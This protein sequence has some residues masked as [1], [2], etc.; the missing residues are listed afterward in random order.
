MTRRLAPQPW[1]AASATRRLFAAL[2]A[3]GAAVRFV[4]GCVR[5]TLLGRPVKDIDLATDATPEQVMAL[6]KSAGIKAVPT[7]IAHGTVTAIVDG[8]PYEI[9]TLRVDVETDGRHATVAYGT[10]WQADAARR[11][12]TINAMSLAPDGILFDPFGGADDLAAGRIR[13]VGTARDRIIEDVLRLLRWFRFHAFYGRP[14]PDAEALDACRTLAPRLAGLSRE[15]VRQETLRLLEAPDPVP[16]L[17]LMRETGVLAQL[18]DGATT[19]DR[20]AGLRRIEERVGLTPDP[21]LRLAALLPEV[22]G[23]AESTSKRLRLSKA[24]RDRLAALLAGGPVPTPVLDGQARRA[25]AYRLG[26]AIARDRILLAWASEPEG[27]GW[28]ALYDDIGAWPV[29]RL[30]VAGRDARKLGVP[31]GPRVGELLRAVEAWW[32][33]EDFHPDRAACLARLRSLAGH[34]TAQD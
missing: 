14:P 19:L 1:M 13:F 34:D 27:A 10:D 8:R 5:D 17:R 24:E 11:D 22:P 6:L 25:V 29:P 12:L 3:K 18:L 20:I 32:I 4:G 23:I 7:G 2:T 28:H 9:T 26:R 33:A 30:P 31:A 21:L 15:R 16:S